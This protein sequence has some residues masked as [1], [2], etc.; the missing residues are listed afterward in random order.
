MAG[1]TAHGELWR[2]ARRQH[3]V[4]TRDQLVAAGLTRHAIDHRVA[5]GRL[6]RL[7][8]GVFA[9]GRRALDELGRWMA[10]ILACGEGAVL[11]HESAGALWGIRPVPAKIDVSV[12]RSRAPRPRCVVVHRRSEA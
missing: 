10:A 6:H 8:R 2:L 11:S 9:V 7:Y 1:T 5:T 4:V 3:W 12:P